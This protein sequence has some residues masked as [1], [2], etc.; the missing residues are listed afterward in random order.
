MPTPLVDRHAR[1]EVEDALED[2]RVVVLSGARQVGKTTL[3][4]RLVRERG[5][6]YLTLDDPA[7]ADAARDDPEGLVRDRTEPV[8]V[9]E[10]QR[11]GDALVRA[12][13][14]AVDDDPRPG[15][16][17]LTGSARFTTV[18]TVSESLAGRAALVDLWPFSQGELEGVV[19]GFLD[20]L[21]DDPGSLSEVPAPLPT[22][23]LRARLVAG[24]Y[25]EAVARPAGRRRDRWFEG[26]LRTLVQR[27]VREL[28]DVRR[29][30]D[31]PRLLRLLAARTA[32]E[33]DVA[34][35][36]REAGLPRSTLQDY[37]PLLE[38][39]FLL[40]R[41][42]AWSR[43]VTSKVV[44]RP[45]AYL[46]D[47][48]LAAHLVGVEADGLGAPGV[49]HAGPLMETFVVGELRKQ[50]T[51]ARRRVDLHHFRD[52][53]G[54]E[55]DVVAETPDGRVA[56]V[57]VKAGRTVRS[58]DL[59]ALRLLRDRVGGAFRAGVLLHGG[60]EAHRFG[61]RLLALPIPVLWRTPAG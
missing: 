52:R 1:R 27:D 34:D 40:T 57:E 9:D 12:V 50:R 36:A 23:E 59:A 45:K 2:A 6:T 4:R 37:V 19:E 18:P 38:T 14:R 56:A 47:T 41:S 43:N 20:R 32:Q 60:D 49:P 55:V 8:V 29:L 35:L 48:G 15:R 33:T 54:P 44:R 21:F 28:A 3:V 26:Y 42:P 10:V 53:S 39:V 31:L 11:G 46:T 61:D 24:G 5:G 16:Y 13:K 30:D 7:V 17:L 51:W 58:A 25:P 22:D